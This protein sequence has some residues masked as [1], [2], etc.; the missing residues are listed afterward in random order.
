[1]GT[2]AKVLELKPGLVRIRQLP[3]LGN[4]GVIF[5]M[6]SRKIPVIHLL[7]IRGLVE[8][9]GLSWDPVPLP[10]PGKER[11]F[12]RSRERQP[13][14]LVLSVVY[15]LLVVCIFIVRNKLR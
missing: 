12:Q 7:F 6:A 13:L 10:S 5:E 15:L 8:R 14:F 2:D 4:R 9:Y 1:M 3:P 11:L